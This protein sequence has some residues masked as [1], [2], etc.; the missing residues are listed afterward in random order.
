MEDETWCT[1]CGEVICIFLQFEGDLANQTRW[2]QRA[3]ALPTNRERRKHAYRTFYSWCEGVG[4]SRKKFNKCVE[5]GV[6]SWYP[7]HAYMGFYTD[8]DRSKRR[9]VVDANGDAI[10]NW[11]WFFKDG[12]WV[13]Q[14][15]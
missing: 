6:R 7:D 9:R 2:H 10:D 8:E 11:W 5:I 13:L 4:G 3:A 1:L 12:V 14:E 15:I